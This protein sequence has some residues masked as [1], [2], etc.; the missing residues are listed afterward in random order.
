MLACFMAIA[1]PLVVYHLRE[2]RI[3]RSGI[4][5]VDAM[6]GQEFEG[7]LAD[8][9]LRAGFGVERTGASADY[10]ADL[11]ISRD[12]RTMVVQAKRYNGAVGV[13]AVQQAA[14]AQAH[15]QAQGA[16]VVTNSRFTR[17][18]RGLAGTNDVQLWDRGVL[19]DVATGRKTIS[20]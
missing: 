3:R 8:I 12:G 16:M 11:L 9:F 14:A 17:Q 1:V 5:R 7:Y 20:R 13:A 15:Y 19:F 4:R 6:N 2:Q 18:A 10:G